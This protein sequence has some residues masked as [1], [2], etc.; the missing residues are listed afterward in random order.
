ML[1]DLMST[2]GS[3]LAIAVVGVGIGFLLLIAALYLLRRRG[4][5]SPFLKGGKN[6]QP[7]LQ[8]LDAAAVDARRRIVLIRRDNIE[9]LVMIGGPTDIVIETGIGA[10]KDGETLLVGKNQAEHLGAP[11]AEPRLEQPERPARIAAPTRQIEKPDPAT[12]RPDE[13]PAATETKADRR[14]AQREQPAARP[15]PAATPAPQPRPAPDI[16]IEPTILPAT[17]PVQPPARSSAQAPANSIPAPQ[18]PQVAPDVG[19]ASDALDA[20]RRRIFQPAQDRTPEAAPAPAQTRQPPSTPQPSEP[21]AAPVKDDKAL[22]ATSE[23]DRILEQEM[24]SN[25]AAEPK[26]P[27]AATFTP[28]LPKR[29]P[30]APKVTGA[31]PDPSLQNEIARIFGEMSVTRDD[32]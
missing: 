31:T 13:M 4:G 16:A 15:A 17:P 9:H 32:R 11:P 8:V 25:L 14:E 20:A 19:A 22:A 28:I 24:A 21:A 7:R 3:R 29:D 23:F 26:A 1:E 12:P 27:A 10:A 6:R 30:A 5:P 2:Y 18:S